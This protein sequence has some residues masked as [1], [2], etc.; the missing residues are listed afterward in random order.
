MILERNQADVGLNGF[1]RLVIPPSDAA[2][3]NGTLAAVPPA[4][5][6]GSINIA[7]PFTSSGGTLVINGTT[8]TIPAKSDSAAI[9]SAI[10]AAGAGVTAS[11]SGGNQLVLT[12]TDATKSLDIAASNPAVGNVLGEVGLTAGST[13][14][15]NLI[16]GTVPL[17][18]QTLTIQ[19]GPVAANMLTI[20]FGG[21]PGQVQNLG[22]LATALQSLTGGIATIDPS[23]NISVA[24][25][26]ATDSITIGGTAPVANFGLAAGVVAPPAAGTGTQLSLTEDAVT[27][28]FGFKLASTTSNLTGVTV[29]QPSGSPKGIAINVTGTPNV[30]ESLTVNVNLPDGTI[31]KVTLT[32]TAASPPPPDQF[33]IG[34]TPGATAAN[35]Q[36]ALTAS[37]STLAATQLTAASAIAAA[38]NFF[39]V[40][41]GQPAQRVAGPPFATATALRNGTPADT[42]SWYMGDMAPNPR[43][44]VTAR[45]DSSATVG[46]GVQANEQALRTVIENVAVFAAANFVVGNPNSNAAYI[47]LSRRIGTNL[48]AQPGDGTQKTSDIETDLA[49]VQTSIQTVTAQQQQTQVTLQNFVQGI[50]GVSNETVAS[51]ILALQTQLQASLQTTAMLSKLSLTNYI[52]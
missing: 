14:P 31:D 29:S 8:V 11:L 1:G 35:I 22:Q 27:S 16:P 2:R 23:G 37:V 21:G 49:N 48:N 51:E 38:N 33:T 41:A 32:A 45:I 40:D 3:V 17:A 47:A 34:A 28:Q 6:T 10:N 9:V 30:G 25:L 13:P 36:A 7:P 5:V 12:N 39:D 52:Q 42:V 4:S 26:N 24:G 44:S 20:T 43:Q 15:P 50:T 19:V 46:Y 18:G